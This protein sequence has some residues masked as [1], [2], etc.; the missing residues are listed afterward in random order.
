MYLTVFFGDREREGL[1][2]SQELETGVSLLRLSGTSLFLISRRIVL[3]FL[4][5]GV[6]NDYEFG[7]LN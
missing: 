5:G 1:V 6:R 2:V 7:V 3:H 4:I